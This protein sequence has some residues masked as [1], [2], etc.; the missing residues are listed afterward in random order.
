MTLDNAHA[1][2]IGISKY[3]HVSPLPEVRDAEDIATLLADPS[4]CGYP[5]TNVTPLLEA[6]ATR[7]AILAALDA[8]AARTQPSSTVFLYFSGHGG[9]NGDDCY[10]MPIDGVWNQPEDL[11]RTAISGRELAERLHAIA[12]RRFTIVLDCCH[13]SGLAEPKHALPIALQPELP[14]HLLSPLARGRGRVVL[15]ASRSDGLAYVQ[16]GQRNGIFTRHLLEGL[17]GAAG[18]VGG[19]VR[20][21]DLFDYVQQRVVVEQPAQ[22]PVFK[23]D[24][25][26]NYAVALHRGGAAPPP[27][28][29]PATDALKY[30]AFVSYR[31]ADAADRAWVEKV[32]TPRL[33]AMGLRLCLEA[34]DFRLGV[35]RIREME[36]AVV[37]SRYT[38]GV[39]TPSY[40]DGAFEDFQSLMA[41]HHSLERKAPRFLPLLRRDCRP[42]LGVRM[43]EWLDLTSDEDVEPG[44][45]RLATR[46]REPPHPNLSA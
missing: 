28:V 18:G 1:L 2:A 36:R 19:V 43:T 6:A 38:V 37:E 4:F 22:R 41:Q 30:D 16:P 8:L 45:L 3:T 17:R 15:A 26:E 39:F 33:E 32:M 40:L 7:T 27:S 10:L 46:L 24:I 20:V 21:C 14:A 35:P 11:A 31:R 25:E 23:A 42:N 13:A 34:R 9:A 44:L 5:T 12:A 29:P